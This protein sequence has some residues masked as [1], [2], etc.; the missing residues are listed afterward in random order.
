MDLRVDIL[1]VGFDRVA[2]VDAVA[3]IEQRLDSGERTFI[4]TA[5]PEFVMLCRQ[6]PEVAEIAE[7][8]DLVV[9][10]GTRPV[11]PSPP[12]PPPLPPPP[13]PPPPRRRRRPPRLPRRRGEG[14]AGDRPPRR[15]RVALAARARAPTLAQTA[16]A[17][18]LRPPRR[19]RSDASRMS[20][21]LAHEY[22]SAHGGAERVVEVLHRMYP[23]AP[24]YTFFHDPPAYRVLPGYDPPTSF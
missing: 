7:P 13:P 9:P 6:D 24:V 12:P 14:P 3:R 1:G 11:V 23:Y 18:A 4:I 19:A 8:A 15:P 10:D 20:L 22:F 17:A 2:L 21:A 16:R 5:N